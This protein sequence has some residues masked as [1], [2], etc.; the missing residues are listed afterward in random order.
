MRRRMRKPRT[1]RTPQ[2]IIHCIANCQTCNWTE[3]GY[4]KAARAGS[5]HTRRTGHVV[6]VEQGTTYEVRPLHRPL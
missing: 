5:I 4:L 3:E 6:V 2:R 1:V